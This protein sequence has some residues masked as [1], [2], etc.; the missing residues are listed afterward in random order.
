NRASWL[1]L[2]THAT[3]SRAFAPTLRE[4][5]EQIIELVSGLLRT[6]TRDP[7]PSV[8]LD[9][10][11]VALVAAGEAVATQVSAG[12]ADVEEAGELMFNRFWRGLKGAPGGRDAGAVAG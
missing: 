12:D 4:G 2:Y 8:D 7:D 3:S 6:G 11:A 1:V 9:M 5:R 10:M